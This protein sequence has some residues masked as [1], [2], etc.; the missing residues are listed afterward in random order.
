[1]SRWLVPFLFVLLPLPLLAQSPRTDPRLQKEY[2]VANYTKHEYRIPMRDGVKLFTAV[3]VPKDDSKKYP[4]MMMRTPY[5]VAPYGVDNY[6]SSL[7]PT[8]AYTTDKFIFVYQDVR[9]RWMSEGEF[10]NMRPIKHDQ[11]NETDESTDTFDTI[12]WL[13]KNV[14]NHNGKVG[15]T[16]I[17]YPGHYTC[18][19]MVDAHPALKASSPQAPVTDW[20][21]GDDFHHNG[22]FFL[23]HAFNFMANFGKPRPEPTRTFDYLRFDHQTPDGYDFFLNLGPLANAEKK[24]FKGQVAFWNEMMQ[25]GLYDEYWQKKNMRQYLKNVKPAVLTV[26]GWFDAENLFGALECYK[27]TETGSPNNPNNTLVMGPWDHGGWNRGDASSLGYAQ[28]GSKTGPFYRDN[29]ELP[30]FKKHLKDEG[31]WNPPEAW[32]FE[33]GSNTWRTYDSWPP[34]TALVTAFHLSENGEL[35]TKSKSE[36]ASGSD[37]FISD[38]SKPVPF[39]EKTSV[40]MEREYMTADQRFASRRPD[41]LVYQTPVLE[42]DLTVSGPIEVELHVTTTS[43]DADWVVKV[44]DVFPADYPDPDPNPT[45]VRMGNYQMLVRGEPFRGKFRNGF[46][47]A[48]PFEPNQP[49]TIKFT[50]PDICHSFRTG[51]RLMI[52]V[53]STWFPLVDRNPQ[54]FTDIYSASEKDFVKATHKVLRGAEH[55]SA[56]RM[57]VVK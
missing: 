35:T 52:Q 30:F 36:I 15:Q 8:F 27:A 28:F 31:N 29:I 56:I 38:P 20:F 49:A 51:H 45:G 42:S 32:V 37:E 11:P 6:R 12:E 34:K 16:G 17:S 54:T 21:V 40:G 9:G 46:D 50:M 47:K 18:A 2:V 22:C 14:K 1:M 19:G 24:Y 26:G 57:R 55:P 23:P 3:Y 33:T 41:V 5:S 4:M 13:L 44:I 39:I 48:T 25:H 7:G 10:V 53:Q 43:T